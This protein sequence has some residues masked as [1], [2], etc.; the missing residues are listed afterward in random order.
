MQVYVDFENVKVSK[1]HSYKFTGKRFKVLQVIKDI[2]L[3][4][5]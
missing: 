3:V 4:V 5:F 1:R 2:K